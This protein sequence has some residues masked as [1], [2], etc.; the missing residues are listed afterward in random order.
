MSEALGIE[1]IAIT[2]RFGA[3]TALDDVAMK[4]PPATFHALL[5]EN[6]AGKSTLVKCLM[7][8]YRP[9]V[10]S[11]L[12]DDREREISSPRDAHQLGIG[13]VYQHFTLVPNMTVAENLVMGR[14]RV[15]AII[16]WSAE[17]R[18][19]DEFMGR[20]PFAIRLDSPVS[21]LAAGEKQKVEILKQLYLDR[22]VLILD[23][24][25]SVLTPGEADEVLG[26]LKEMVRQ[27]RLTVLMI[28]HKF[29]E[30]IAFADAVTVLRR[31]R[32]SGVGAVA[33][34]S[35]AM[36][37][38][39]LIGSEQIPQ[40]SGKT[41]TEA[42]DDRLVIRDLAAND[43]AGAVAVDGVNLTVRAGEIVGIAGVSG[44]GQSEFL[45]VLAGQREPLGGDILVHGEPYRRT[46]AE[47]A[48]H[49]VFCL[50][51]EPLR[52]ACVPPMSV[53][54]NLAFRVFDQP[55]FA[56]GGWWL[57]RAAIREKARQLIAR[58]RVKTP[59]PETPI[60]TLSGGNVQRT[61][62]ARELSGDV[63]VLIVANPCFGLDFFAVAEIRSQ[64]VQARNRGVAVLLLS[65]D[66][67][68]ILELADRI[69]VMFEGKLVY[70]TPVGAADLNAIGA[71]MAGH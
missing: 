18:K 29:R 66:L 19:L 60:G 16:D 1:A 46:R 6:G 41:A 55:H 65:E 35:P 22:R 40:S 58:Y 53:G 63:E 37:A 57:N 61:V 71:H 9:D 50:P 47:M 20:M 30:V 43:D 70:E 23:E 36:L 67:D 11:V 26:M 2:K 49:K 17:R 13:M 51:E 39:M 27:G 34:L 12:I 64:I 4:V 33:D 38:T 10:G 56:I 15:P 44:N 42:V 28:T 5:G 3:L 31:G 8:Y 54:Q 59:S 45:Q 14:S 21:R 48:R 7:G 25:T 24:P 62:L 69:M 68:E 32:L 52:N